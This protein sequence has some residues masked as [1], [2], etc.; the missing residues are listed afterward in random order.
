MDNGVPFLKTILPSAYGY[1]EPTAALVDLHSHGVDSEWLT[2]RAA[3]G[4]FKQLDLKP[5]SGHSV[6]HLIAMGA[7]D[8]YGCLA[9]N[10]PIAMADGSHKPIAAV[11][12]DDMVLSGSGDIRRATTT[13]NRVVDGAYEITVE[14]LPAPIIMSDN[15]PVEVARVEQFRCKHDKYK[16]CMP[17]IK[18]QLN[19]CKRPQ[20]KDCAMEPVEDVKMERAEAETLCCGDY[21]IFKIP[22]VK[23][24]RTISPE[25]GRLI[26]YWLAEG[27]FQRSYKGGPIQSLRFSFGPHEE[28]TLV[29]DCLGLLEHLGMTGHKYPDEIKSYVAVTTAKS[30]KLSREYFDWFSSGAHNKRLPLWVYSLPNEV[31]TEIVYGYFAGDGTV[32]INNKDNRATACTVSYDLAMGTQRLLWSLGLP[33][34]VCAVTPYT[35]G[36]GSCAISPYH[37]SYPLSAAAGTR[38]SFGG[39]SLKQPTKVR[40][41]VHDSIVYLAIRGIRKLDWNERVYNLEIEE[42]HDYVGGGFYSHNCNRNGD[43][44]L[45]KSAYAEIPNPKEG[46]PRNVKIDQGLIETH[47]TFEKYAKVY[48]NHVNKDP[49][50]AHGD[51][52][53]SAFN[54]SMDRVELLI[55]VAN[56][57]WEAEIQDLANEKDVDFSMSCKVPYDLCTE[58]G[59]KAANRSQYCDHLK[60][61]MTEITKQGNQ[62]GAIND[63]QTF[64][65]ISRVT[66][67]A[68]RIALGLLKAASD[69]SKVVSGAELS[70]EFNL[71][72]PVDLG[73]VDPWFI[74]PAMTD[75]KAVLRKLSD[76]EKEIEGIGC[77][78]SPFN[79][80]AMSMGPEST[81]DIAD[82]DLESLQVPRSQTMDLLGSLADVKIALSLKDLM[83]II[84]GKRYDEASSSVDE[85]QNMLPGVFSREAESSEE[86][87][88]FDFGNSLLPRVVRDT[89]HK[90]IPS[91]SLGEDPVRRRVVITVLRGK[92][93]P[94]LM[95]PIG[96]DKEGSTSELAERLAKAYASYKVAFCQRAGLENKVLTKLAVLQHYV[97]R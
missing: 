70:E 80:L 19:I 60:N 97:I 37:V 47:R 4:V 9:G 56:D 44:F 31:K 23:P 94:K 29:A 17:P 39:R 34:V 95:S 13:Y 58:C 66:T 32:T 57:A 12:V 7:S 90:L 96:L 54:D 41:F 35:T 55:K 87:S 22:V 81:P 40:T 16:R 83:K 49:K 74:A 46:T 86:T 27:S 75:K 42:D 14:G 82:D 68:D 25:E 30:V 24:P 36:F 73:Y 50:K 45:R 63:H 84:L 48:R 62:I 88:D 18:G 53:K 8:R 1:S 72:P 3:A 78:D 5:E 67:R 77:G 92:D 15:H 38:L 21:L 2:K 26:G 69:G 61:H 51:V 43:I 93:A 11:E 28:H 33:A 79:R 85:A 52:V 64:F 71:C 91:H 65:D 10:T 76:I 20:A 6:I 89:I 59:N